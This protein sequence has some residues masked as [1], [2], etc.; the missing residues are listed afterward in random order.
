MELS[1]MPHYIVGAINKKKL[2][3]LIQALEY[4][5]EDFIVVRITSEGGDSDI[6]LAMAGLLQSSGKTVITE[7]YG[8]CY[9]AATLIFAAGHTRRMHRWAWIMVHEGSESVEGN[10]SFIKNHAKQMERSENKWNLIMEECTGTESKVWEKLNEKDTYLDAT[11]A[12]KL[13]LA[14]EIF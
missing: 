3:A 11:E 13:N 9:S 10:A 2:E 7:V 5:A 14:T 8:Q 12:L 1:S 4:N 6:A